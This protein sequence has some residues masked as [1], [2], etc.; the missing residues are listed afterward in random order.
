MGFKDFS[1][2]S[3]ENYDQKSIC[4][5][6]VDV[7]S[8]MSGAAIA[9][10]NRGLQEFHHQISDD[11]QTA[12]KLEVAVVQFGSNVDTIVSPAL[13]YNFEMPHLKAHGST[14]LV[15]GVRKAMK[16]VEGRKDWY[17][18][19]GQP[20][21]RPWIILITDGEPDQ[22]QDINGLSME[23]EEGTKNKKFVFLPIGVQGANM[24]ILEKIAGYN[25]KG[26]DWQKM[27]PMKLRGLKF[28]EFFEW[29]SASMSVVANS[30]EEE[31]VNLPDIGN[32]MEGFEI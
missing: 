2:E 10:L 26:S 22:G 32:W 12:N 1:A 17:K 21:L 20:Y 29:V 23:I 4:C 27:M 5:F 6:V 19:T 8:S 30:T 11:Y 16:L 18:M 14:K 3:P 13:P 28:A 15:D 31:S 25:K 24:G 9:E 7:S